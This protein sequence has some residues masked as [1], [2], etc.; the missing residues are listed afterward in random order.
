[1]STNPANDG[2]LAF[3]KVAALAYNGLTGTFHVGAMTGAPDGVEMTFDTP[4]DQ[5]I[6][7]SNNL[8]GVRVKFATST[9]THIGNYTVTIPTSV[10]SVSHSI[11]LPVTITVNINPCP[12]GAN[13]P[14][15]A[16]ILTA[17][18]SQTEVSANFPFQVTG[19]LETTGGGPVPA[20]AVYVQPTWGSGVSGATGNNG[21]FSIT[22]FASNTPGTYDL[23]VSFPGDSQYS[24]SEPVTLRI[25][26]RQ[27]DWN[28]ILI[29]VA[30]IA[31]IVVIGLAYAMSRR[32]KPGMP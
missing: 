19:T 10:G 25:T 8:V 9:S 2:H 12:S 20:G 22:V 5:E 27:M 23:H 16:T 29:I 32:A 11:T 18:L 3:V 1:M 15:I 28:T 13:C 30:V 7:T 24:A 14:T 6:T 21:K 4:N 17:E 26:V 31:V